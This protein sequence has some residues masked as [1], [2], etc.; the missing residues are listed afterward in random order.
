MLNSPLSGL[1]MV[2]SIPSLDHSQAYM[3]HAQDHLLE[4]SRE[5]VTT[6]IRVDF[7]VKHIRSGPLTLV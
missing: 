3:N 1:G 7:G 2:A 4:W 5:R 6:C